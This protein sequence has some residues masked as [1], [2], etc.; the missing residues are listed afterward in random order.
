MI[1]HDPAWL[2][3]LCKP[4]RGTGSPG[5]Q[6]G[7]NPFLGGSSHPM[8][9]PRTRAPHEWEGLCWGGLQGWL[10]D[11]LRRNECSAWLLCRAVASPQLAGGKLPCQATG[12]FLYCQGCNAGAGRRRMQREGH[13]V[14]EIQLFTSLLLFSLSAMSVQEESA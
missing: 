8:L 2:F 9:A 3:E 12:S 1:C 4:C 7:L 10:S 13:W 14:E 5:A 6:R 11:R